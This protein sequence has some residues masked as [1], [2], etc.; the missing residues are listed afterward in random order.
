M[1][2]VTG[3]GFDNVR[4]CAFACVTFRWSGDSPMIKSVVIAALILG[5]APLAAFA[6]PMSIGGEGN[7]LAANTIAA[8]ASGGGTA[9]AEPDDAVDEDATREAPTTTDS[10]ASSR[11]RRQ[12]SAEPA[13]PRKPAHAPGAAHKKNEA[14]RWQSLLPGVMK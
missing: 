4:G 12:P 10:T 13:T 2:T 1:T 6:E 14:T 3:A 8:S 7:L 9:M 11:T 5:I